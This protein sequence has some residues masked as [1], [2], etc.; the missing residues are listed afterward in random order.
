ML[1]ADIYRKELLTNIIK[2]GI[3]ENNRINL[4][5]K[6]CDPYK[7]VLLISYTFLRPTGKANNS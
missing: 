3:R 1:I 5:F 6:V 4:S 2:E 7:G